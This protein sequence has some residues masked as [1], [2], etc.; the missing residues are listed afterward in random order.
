MRNL[1]FHIEQAIARHSETEAVL[2][3]IQKWT[4]D[5]KD[6][7]LKNSLL[8]L[9]DNLTELFRAVCRCKDECTAKKGG[10]NA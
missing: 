10:E 7:T 6:L 4:D 5:S 3:L 8:V 9:E 1:E 2:T